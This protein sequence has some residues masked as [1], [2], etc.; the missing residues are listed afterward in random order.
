MEGSSWK[1]ERGWEVGFTHLQRRGRRDE[2]Q[3]VCRNR[4][5]FCGKCKQRFG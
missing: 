2:K 3:S 5:E 1:D 4:F